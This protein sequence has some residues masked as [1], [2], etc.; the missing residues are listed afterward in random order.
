MPGEIPRPDDVLADATC[1]LRQAGSLQ[2]E[3]LSRL[4]REFGAAAV[5]Q[6]QAVGAQAAAVGSRPLSIQ[7]CGHLQPSILLPVGPA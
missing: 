2:E 7:S 3:R 5:P 1:N 6:G 4:H